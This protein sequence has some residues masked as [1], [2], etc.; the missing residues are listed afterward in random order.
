M[1]IDETIVQQV[2]VT[3]N[4][5]PSKS[6][7]EISR[8]VC[9]FFSKEET[10]NRINALFE[11]ILSQKPSCRYLSKYFA[12]LVLHS[13]P[14]SEGLKIILDIRNKKI[15]R[16]FKDFCKEFGI[17]SNLKKYGTSKYKVFKVIP[18]IDSFDQKAILAGEELPVSASLFIEHLSEYCSKVEED[19]IRFFLP[20]IKFN[21]FYEKILPELLEVN[22]GYSSKPISKNI[23]TLKKKF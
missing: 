21:R 4:A 17:V 9:S 5:Y 14:C 6:I 10:R 15:K 11:G 1:I 18:K 3:V 16:L 2:L 12:F 19:E 7:K 23:L 20:K 13:R 8:S 22:S